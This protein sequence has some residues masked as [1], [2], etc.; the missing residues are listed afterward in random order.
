MQ[1]LADILGAPVDRPQVTETTALGAAW[2]AG[3]KA[4]LCGGPEDL[5]AAWA[6]ERRFEPAMAAVVRD[7]RHARWK[8]AVAAVM[9]L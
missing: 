3:W 9:S 7:A 5:A 6:L 2:L 4:G 8:R 1:F